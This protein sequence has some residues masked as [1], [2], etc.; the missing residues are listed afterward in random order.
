MTLK[1]RR[2][3]YFP[4]PVATK[5]SKKERKD[6]RIDFVPLCARETFIEKKN[7][8][9]RC[10]KTPIVVSYDTLRHLAQ[11]DRVASSSEKRE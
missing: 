10:A 4:F 6:E 9:E 11:S 7:S 2:K 8:R 3:N 5:V 1:I